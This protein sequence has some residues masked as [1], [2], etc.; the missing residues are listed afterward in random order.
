MY[1]R[2][3]SGAVSMADPAPLQRYS[4]SISGQVFFQEL[5]PEKLVPGCIQGHIS[6]Y[7]RGF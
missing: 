1:S 6:A 2:A 7:L 5:F 4:R 3:D